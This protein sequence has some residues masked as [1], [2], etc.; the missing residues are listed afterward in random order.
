MPNAIS[1]RHAHLHPYYII[2]IASDTEHTD[3]QSTNRIR[4]SSFISFLNRVARE[5]L[6]S[7]ANQMYDRGMFAH[8]LAQPASDILYK[9]RYKT[10]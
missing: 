9:A 2:N 1:K 6:A 4:C 8:L 5:A 10:N 7:A 3:T